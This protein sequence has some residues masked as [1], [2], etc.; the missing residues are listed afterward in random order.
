MMPREIVIKGLETMRTYYNEPTIQRVVIERAITLLNDL[1]PVK[2][3]LVG[4]MWEC[5]NCHAPVGIYRDDV[6][7]EFCRKCGKQVKWE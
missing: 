1:E 4:H 2:P 6:R 3:V 7:D 5:G